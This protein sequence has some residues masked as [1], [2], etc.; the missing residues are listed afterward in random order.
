TG[1][2]RAV[3]LTGQRPGEVSHMRHEHVSDG[4]WTLPG[5]PD[6]DTWWPGTKNGQTHRVWLPESIYSAVAGRGH[7][8]TG[9][10]FAG[11]RGA[12]AGAPAPGRRDICKPPGVQDKV[13]PHARRRPHGSTITNP[14]F[15]RA[16]MTRTQNPRGGGIADVYDRHK[17]EVENKRV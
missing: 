11:K 10:V 15:G 5:A 13:P 14:G 6:P 17:Y 9:F 8:A 12:A 7:L 1:A 4:W 3:L 16:A 2:L